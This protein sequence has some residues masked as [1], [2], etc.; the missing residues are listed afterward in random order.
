MIIIIIIGAVRGIAHNTCN[1]NY[2]PNKCMV[3]VFIHNAK[4]YDTHLILSHAN[5]E[6]HGRIS[7]IP[8]TT[9][10]YVSFRIGNLIFKDSMQFMN[11]SL[12]GLVSSM[13]K[14]E[15]QTTSNF[16]KNYVKQITADPEVINTSTLGLYNVEV[17]GETFEI[18]KPKKKSKK[19]TN[20]DPSNTDGAS[21]AK[22]ARTEFLD[23]DVEVEDQMSGDETEIDFN[24]E[25]AEDHE[26]IVVSDDDDDEND[27]A[28]MHRAF[29]Q[30]N[31]PSSES[32]TNIY[33]PQDY[34]R[35]PYTP[36]ELNE[37]ET[38]LYDALFELICSKGVYFYEHV[39]SLDVLDETSLPPKENFYSHLTAESITDDEYR[40]AQEVWRKFRMN[41]LWN[42]HDMYLIMDVWLLADVLITFQNVCYKNYGIDPLHSYTTP[43]FGWQSLLKMTNAKLELL[44][45]KDKDIYLFFEAAKRGGL[46]VIGHRH[47]KANIPGREDFDPEKPI[48]WLIYLDANNLYGNY[49]L[50]SLFFS[51]RN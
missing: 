10:Q 15:L 22:R 17:P 49:F 48:M 51:I 38:E 2:K 41:T 3:N 30:Q 1:V 35:N 28:S 12:D 26:F 21:K 5:P 8:P 33:P 6:K 34:R 50:I 23:E 37:S 18:G 20:D 46:S 44:S 43:G 25:T 13:D 36:P 9:E 14:S 24:I 19:T 42:Y 11:K 39:T 16:L 4:S 32:S 45:E 7:C 27:D 29:D 47:A 40:R 31:P